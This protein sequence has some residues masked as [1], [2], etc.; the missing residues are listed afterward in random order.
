MTFRVNKGLRRATGFREVGCKLYSVN[1]VAGSVG[2][3]ELAA[4]PM[5]GAKSRFCRPCSLDSVDHFR[6][7]SQTPSRDE[8][9]I[10]NYSETP[11]HIRLF[12]TR[13][14]RIFLTF[15]ENP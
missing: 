6:P 12:G 3:G 14:Y 4:G 11:Y 9:T 2:L 7:V 15:S 13:R 8:K 5:S 1:W 10:T